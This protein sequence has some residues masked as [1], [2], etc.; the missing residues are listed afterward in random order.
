MGG[1]RLSTY[2][3]AKQ[4]F[5]NPLEFD[6]LYVWQIGRRYCE[7]STV[8]GDHL[9]SSMTAFDLYELTVVTDGIGTV[10]TNHVDQ[11]VSAGDI[12]L[13]F[14]C[15][16]HRIESSAEKP[17]KFDHFAFS[18]KD[19]VYSDEFEKITQNFHSANSRIFRDERVQS[20]ISNAI[21][22]LISENSYSF[23]ILGLIL[24]QI[25]IYTVRGFGNKQGT[26]YYEN[27]SSHEVLCYRLMN[28]I[29]THI[30]SIKRLED[31]AKV[32]NYSYGYLTAVFR[33]TTSLTLS[34]YYQAKRLDLAR[35]LVI[36]GKL[37]INEI[38]EKLG[39]SSVYAFSKAFAKKHGISPKIYRENSRNQ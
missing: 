13:S 11:T 37:K 6:E 27:V 28:Y 20:L 17:L 18:L 12:Y 2:N 39:Y 36:E 15:D 19:C 30:Y 24:K 16:I 25:I 5:G 34:E 8:I 4:Y 9:H 31:L 7:R 29:D 14:P 35:L 26:P 21:A 1:D 32:T 10:S 33:K 38:S 3:F 23:E 22:E